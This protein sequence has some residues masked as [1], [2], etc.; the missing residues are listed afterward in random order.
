M[1]NTSALIRALLTRINELESRLSAVERKEAP[2]IGPFVFKIATTGTA[3]T[4]GG[5]FR[6][7]SASGTYGTAKYGQL[8]Y[9]A[10]NAEVIEWR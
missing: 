9:T 6:I 5:T 8:E 2:K 4:D 1:Y 3:F 7:G 10:E